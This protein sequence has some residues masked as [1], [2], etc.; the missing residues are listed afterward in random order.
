MPPFRGKTTAEV[1]K[2]QLL[3]LPAHPKTYNPNVP[4]WLV[5]MNFILLQKNPEHRFSSARDVRANLL[6]YSQSL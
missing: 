4:D 5:Q 1:I 3:H 2:S 6:E